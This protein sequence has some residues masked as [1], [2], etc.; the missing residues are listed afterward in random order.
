MG[1]HSNKCSLD[2]ID[3]VCGFIVSTVIAGGIF[4]FALSCYLGYR[5]S[6]DN[7]ISDI[8]H[9]IEIAKS[10]AVGEFI[11]EMERSGIKLP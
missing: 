3:L 7:A 8:Q 2:T 9:K 11:E 5:I 4:M 6:Y 10:Q 1:K